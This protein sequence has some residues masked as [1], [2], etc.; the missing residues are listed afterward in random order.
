M[1]KNETEKK[2]SSNFFGSSV[3]LSGSK[4]QTNKKSCSTRV[5]S[6]SRLFFSLFLE[7][8]TVLF[9]FAVLHY[10]FWNH[11]KPSFAIFNFCAKRTKQNFFLFSLQTESFFLFFCWFSGRKWSQT[12]SSGK[13]KSKND[14]EK[15][16]F[17]FFVF[18]LKT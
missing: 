16:L 1:R 14:K 6:L 3:S 8:K 7:A 5:A 17:F 13:K 2:V 18:W 4:K 15:Q 12:A 9:F 10:F 11:L